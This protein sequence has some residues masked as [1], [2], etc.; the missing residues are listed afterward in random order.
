MAPVSAETKQ[1]IGQA[2]V[3][4][5]RVLEF[6]GLY[7]PYL[8]KL[9]DLSHLPSETQLIAVLGNP[10]LEKTISE[11]PREQDMEVFTLISRC[12]GDLDITGP[13]EVTIGHLRQA[14]RKQIQSFI[15]RRFPRDRETGEIPFYKRMRAT[16]ILKKLFHIRP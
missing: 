9:P 10:V 14:T 4:I 12:T 6:T 13:H 16:L 11:L 8:D 3:G 5:Q 15:T 2:L 7:P 1:V